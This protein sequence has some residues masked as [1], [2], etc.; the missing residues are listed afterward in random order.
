LQ[1]RNRRKFNVNKSP[2]KQWLVP[3]ERNPRITGRTTFLQSLREKLFDEVP[4]QFNHRVALYGMGGIGKTQTALEYV[5]ANEKNYARTYWISGVD[6]TSLLS[7]YVEIAKMAGVK[8][9]PDSLPLETARSVLGWLREQ[10]SWL[11]VIDNLDVIEVIEGFLPENGPQKHTI[12]TTRN[13]DSEGIPAQGVEVPLLDSEAAVHLLSTLSGIAIPSNS[14]EQNAAESIVQRLDCLPLAIEQAGAFIRQVTRDYALFLES[15]EKNRKEL[16]KWVPRGNR[17]YKYSVATTWFLSF[18]LIR[19]TYPN[20]AKLFRILS[21]LNPDGI[22]IDFLVASAKALEMDLRDIIENDVYRSNVLLEL[23]KF[24]LIKWNRAQGTVVIHRLVQ[25]VIRDEMQVE[26]H[27]ICSDSIIDMCE[28]AFPAEWTPATRT[29]GGLY[30]GQVLTPLLGVESQRKK[31]FTSVLSTVG[32][33]LYHDGKYTD[34]ESVWAKIV[35]IDEILGSGEV[36]QAEVFTAM[37]YLALAY[38]KQGKLTEALKMNEEVL[39]RWKVVLGE[40]HPNTLTGMSNLAFTYSNQG[41][42]TEAIKMNE[43]VLA[44]RKVVLGEDH[45]DTL[46]SMSSLALAYSDQGKLT[47]A[48]KMNEEVLAKRKVVLGED[49]PNTLTSM[50]NLALAYSEQGKLTEAVKMNEEVLAKWKVVLGEDHPDTL[51]SMSNLAQA[52]S[53]QGKLTEAVKMNEE[54]LAKREVVL[55]EDH[56][57]TLTSMSN[58]ALAYSKQGKLTEA[59]KMNEEVLAKRK[60]VLGDDHPDTLTSMSNLALAYSK[61]GKLTEAVKMNE[62][63]LAKWKVVLGEDHPDTLTSMSNLALADSNQGKLTEAVKMNEEVLAKWKVVLGEDHPD[64]LTSMNNLALAYSNQG[65]LTEALKMNEEVLAKQKVVLGEDHPD[66]LMG[67]SHLAA[68]YYAQGNVEE[69]TSLFEGLYAKQ[70]LVFGE[71]HPHTLLTKRW[72]DHIAQSG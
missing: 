12:I 28:A 50:N 61:Q 30:L 54:V 64:T 19:E 42:L 53:E 16:H 18:N 32:E 37:S 47:E 29:I 60:V 39:E 43:E 69:A 44:K 48:L 13:P 49:H 9:A 56:P 45:P 5:Y 65:K 1:G 24:S 46:T 71:S 55:G 7:G 57:N 20:I 58:L 51:T 36:D 23:E 6:Q 34:S 31:K 68:V 70:K 10:S 66:T 17:Q 52:Y 40:D 11:I 2:L 33:F 8:L 4:G 41:K 63:V 59:V 26:D 21:F 3:Y 27:M 62:E 38:S 15:Y 35:R 67:M 22:R 14:P 25:A 72:L